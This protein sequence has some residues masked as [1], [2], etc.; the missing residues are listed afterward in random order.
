VVRHAP[1]WYD[2]TWFG[3]ATDDAE[4]PALAKRLEPAIEVSLEGLPLSREV[5][6]GA[7]IAEITSGSRGAHG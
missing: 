6:H 5:S 7:D 1:R 3:F 4:D 2:F